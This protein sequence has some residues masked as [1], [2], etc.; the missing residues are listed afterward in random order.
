MS[1]VAQFASQY[2]KHEKGISILVVDYFAPVNTVCG[3]IS[4]SI[5]NEYLVCVGQ[6][7]L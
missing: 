4:I 1:H 6:T 5:S 3:I 2:I 7:F